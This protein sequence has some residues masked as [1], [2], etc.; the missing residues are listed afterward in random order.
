MRSRPIALV[1]P[2]KAVVPCARG[3]TSLSFEGGS[4]NEVAWYPETSA[5]DEEQKPVLCPRSCD[6]AY[7]PGSS[8]ER[9]RPAR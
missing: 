7:E 5:R 6:P 2:A 4:L 1:R 8:G 9:E 3:A